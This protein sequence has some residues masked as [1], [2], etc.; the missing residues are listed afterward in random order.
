MA[1]KFLRRY[2]ERS[3]DLRAS[4]SLAQEYVSELLQP[5]NYDLHAIT[6]RAKSLE[7]ARTKVLAKGY[8]NPARQLTDQVGIRVITYFE[9]DVD[10]ITKDLRSFLDIDEARS[11]DKRSALA[12]REFGYRSVHLVG[13]VRASHLEMRF[14]SLAGLRVEVQ[15]RSILEHAWAEIEHQVV[16][17]AGIDFPASIRRRFSAIAGTLEI[18]EKEFQA[19]RLQRDELIERYALEARGEQG[20]LEH[21]DA[22]RL[23]GILEVLRPDGLS[24]RLSGGSGSP[25]PP[26]IEARCVMALRHVGVETGQ[27]LRTWLDSGRFNRVAASYAA[28]EGKV[29]SQLSH[30]AVVVL[31]IASRDLDVAL[32][33]LPDLAGDVSVQRALMD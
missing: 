26:R 15:V 23:L 20:Y 22:A 29:P 30:L 4:A 32:A 33:L 28:A 31:A 3:A 19:L 21:L 8:G 17:K 12:L 6:G 13:T 5:G 24:W 11:A 27:D 9:A 7:S 14:R 10:P 25:F 2:S 18:L 16:Y 1:A